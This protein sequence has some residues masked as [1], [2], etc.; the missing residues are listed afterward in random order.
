MALLSLVPLLIATD[1]QPEAQ[2]HLEPGAQHYP[3]L[4]NETALRV[5]TGAPRRERVCI[6]GGGPSG[7]HVAWL[8]KRRL[9][10]NITVYEKNSR[11]GG[12]VWTRPPTPGTGGVNVSRELGAAFLSPD[13]VEVRALL[14]RFGQKEL[15][16]STRTQL[17]FHVSRDGSDHV[18]SASSWAE[19]RVSRYT[20]STNATRNAQAVSAALGRYIGLHRSI[21]GAYSGRFPPEPRTARQLALLNATGLAFLEAHDLLVLEPLL[22]QFFVLQGMGLLRTMPAY[23]LLKWASPASLGAG[24]LGDVSDEPLAMLPAGY[25]ALVDAIAA[26]AAVDVRFGW[27]ALSIVRG[28]AR[29]AAAAAARAAT[30]AEGESTRSAT[31]HF[32]GPQAHPPQTCDLLVLSGPIPEFVAGSLDGSRAPILSPAA[33]AGFEYMAS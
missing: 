15:P 4:W 6:L 3:S 26:E 33:A 18:Q 14:G 21:F 20:N 27:R 12:D 31:I 22:F 7:M 16:L 11:L 25:G 19:E 32:D 5:C 10:T 23:Y 9:F 28:S 30:F 13:Y 2:C 24:G 29:A 8:L 17:E 1:G